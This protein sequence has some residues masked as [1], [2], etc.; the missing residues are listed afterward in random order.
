MI[1][2]GPT[3]DS[4]KEDEFIDNYGQSDDVTIYL[5]NGEVVGVEIS[6][7]KDNSVIIDIWEDEH[8][9]LNF[10][11]IDYMEDAYTKV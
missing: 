6:E 7:V 8:R 3:V 2:F 11:E 5:I 4:W 10:Q 9:E 1:L